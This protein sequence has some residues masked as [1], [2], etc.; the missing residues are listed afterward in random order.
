MIYKNETPLLQLEAFKIFLLIKLKNISKRTQKKMFTYNQRN[1]YDK[2]AS[3]KVID[4]S[5]DIYLPIQADTEFQERV[6]PYKT[7]KDRIKATISVQLKTFEEKDFFYLH[8]DVS[9]YNINIKKPFLNKDFF[10]LQILEDC[11][12]TLKEVSYC[13]INPCK[14]LHV[15]CIGF[16]LVAD[17]LRLFSGEWKEEILSIIKKERKNNYIIHDKR[18]RC[19]HKKPWGVEVPYV[20]LNKSIEIDGSRYNIAIGFMDTCAIQGSIGL[21]SLCINTGIPTDSKELITKEEKKYMMEVLKNH[22][23]KFVQYSLGDLVNLEALIRNGDFLQ[24]IYNELGLNSYYKR[25]RPTIGATVHTLLEGALLSYLDL[26]GSKELKE[27]VQ[28]GSH[29]Y[30]MGNLQSTQTYLAKTSGGRCYNNRRL[31]PSI[32]SIIVDIDISGC[33]GKGLQ[34]Q[35]YPIGRPVIIDYNIKSK[36]NNF[37]SLKDFLKKYGNDLVDGL[38]YCR[39]ST[40]EELSFDQDFFMS[41]YPPDRLQDII[42][43]DT[44]DMEEHE[45]GF[46]EDGFTKIFSR[47]LHLSALQSDSLEWIYTCLTREEREEFMNKCFVVAAAYYPRSLQ[48]RNT[49]EF[50]E[51]R[52]SHNGKNYCE[53]VY[54][55][56]N[57]FEIRKVYKE[58]HAWTSINIGTLLISKLLEKRSLYDKNNPDQAPMNN[59]IKLLI[60]TTYGDLVS[61]FFYIGNTIVGNNITGRARAIAWYMEKGLHGTQTITDGCCFELNKV[62]KSRYTLTNKKYLELSTEGKKK[63]L[64]FSPLLERKF[65]TK[66]VVNL[67]KNRKKDIEKAVKNH[68]KKMFRNNKVLNQFD[69]EVKHICTGLSTHGASNYQLHDRDN[70]IKSK[71]RSYKNLEYIDYD[72]E[73]GKILGTKKVAESFLKSIYENPNKVKREEPFVEDRIIKINNYNAGH[74]RFDKM[75]LLPGNSEKVVRLLNECTLSIFLFR[76]YKQYKSWKRQYEALKRAYKQSYEESY[77]DNEG[78]LKYKEMISDIQEEINNEKMKLQKNKLHEV[79]HPKKE[80]YEKIKEYIEEEETLLSRV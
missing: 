77:T 5:V 70:I 31:E 48:A 34:N 15:D 47:E 29:D 40:K 41:W 12:Y 3:I 57:D 63:D 78:N 58:C 16:F 38:W 18:L 4:G 68:L 11:G 59:F 44:I 73:S 1:Y 35:D 66:E 28:H 79:S 36:I 72:V 22:P 14:T 67:Q 80:K 7:P 51:T 43:T 76:T 46:Y 39:I 75:G 33:Y 50:F 17:F 64:I 26:E 32:N 45:D 71:M 8:E 52:R 10:A 25:P 23:D 54:F 2:S 55:K 6:F 42:K 20:Y 30:L 27:L 9:S 69:F 60:N 49:Q 53:A 56:H 65:H 37:L 61:P 24:S 74:E 19:V 13:P 21:R 62:T